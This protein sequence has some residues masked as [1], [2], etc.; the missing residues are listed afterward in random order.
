MGQGPRARRQSSDLQLS[1]QAALL[2]LKNALHPLKKQIPH[3]KER[4]SE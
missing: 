1:F 4:G 2:P 3:R